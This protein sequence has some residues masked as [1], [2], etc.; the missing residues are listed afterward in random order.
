MNTLEFK[1]AI[2]PQL[3]MQIARWYVHDLTV[4]N[5]H[6]VATNF[7]SHLRAILNNAKACASLRNV[8]D[9]L[10][11]SLK[12]SAHD[13]LQVLTRHVLDVY[14]LAVNRYTHQDRSAALALKV[15]AFEYRLANLLSELKEVAAASAC[16]V[17]S[18]VTKPG[19]RFGAIIGGFERVVVKNHYAPVVNGWNPEKMQY[20]PHFE[21][22]APDTAAF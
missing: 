1:A 17:L 15:R 20:R 2:R 19:V 13:Y 10:P 4:E 18:H 12:P 7:R 5:R 9:E 21:N 14:F 3:E 6:Y 16:P 11:L 22:P 8:L